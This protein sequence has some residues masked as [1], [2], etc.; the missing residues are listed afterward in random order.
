[1]QYVR[2]SLSGNTNSCANV[3][4]NTKHNSHL[5]KLN[6]ATQVKVLHY[7]TNIQATM[8][9][10]RLILKCIFCY[11]QYLQQRTASQPVLCNENKMELNQDHD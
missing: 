10:K 9:R 8:N 7:R 2:Y 4:S 6:S 5:E 1:M 11:Y 3:N